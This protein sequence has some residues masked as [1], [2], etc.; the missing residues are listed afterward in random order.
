MTE[1]YTKRLHRR[2]LAPGQLASARSRQDS[3]CTPRTLGFDHTATGYTRLGDLQQHFQGIQLMTEPYIKR[4]HRRV[5]WPP[6]SWHPPDRGRI[7]DAHPG[8]G[9]SVTARTVK[10]DR[11]ISMNSLNNLNL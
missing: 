4:L 10:P 3:R 2:E 9:E 7:S 5:N 8:L 11:V 1:P 6:G